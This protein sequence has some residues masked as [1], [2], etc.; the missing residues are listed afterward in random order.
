MQQ[1]MASPLPAGKGGE[2]ACF[3]HHTWR[4]F[5]RP[6]VLLLNDAVAGNASIQVIQSESRLLSG[7]AKNLLRPYASFL[8]TLAYLPQNVFPHSGQHTIPFT[9]CAFLVITFATISYPIWRP[10]NHK[11]YLLEIYQSYL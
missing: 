9:L 1:F 5:S 3:M 6:N 2:S 10:I 11:T 7:E 8:N 4:F